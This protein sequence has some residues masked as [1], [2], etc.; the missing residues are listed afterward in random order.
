MAEAE[1]YQEELRELVEVAVTG[2]YGSA[3]LKRRID[4]LLREYKGKVKTAYEVRK[5]W[6]KIKGSMAEEVIRMRT[7]E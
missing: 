5:E 3:A 6:S 7:A 1:A 2:M 4:R